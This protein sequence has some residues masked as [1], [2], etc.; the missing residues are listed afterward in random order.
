MLAVLQ[1]GV[2]RPDAESAS[3][4]T[5]ANACHYTCKYILRQ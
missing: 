4:L 3:Y 2:K 1:G 5:Y